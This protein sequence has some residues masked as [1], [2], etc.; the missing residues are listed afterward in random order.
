MLSFVWRQHSKLFF[1]EYI[2]FIFSFMYYVIAVIIF[3][4]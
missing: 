3:F 4:N 1:T 2:L